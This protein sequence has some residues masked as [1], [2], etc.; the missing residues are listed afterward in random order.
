MPL[1]L[2]YDAKGIANLDML[3]YSKLN[4]SASQ[5]FDYSDTTPIDPSILDIWT[6]MVRG[7][8]GSSG[9]FSRPQNEENLESII[10]LAV[11][12]EIRIVLL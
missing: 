6:T 11:E 5:N 8:I 10:S 1:L 4:S 7:I 3:V 2:D 12:E 9:P